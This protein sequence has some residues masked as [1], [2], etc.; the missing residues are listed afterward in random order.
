MK[1]LFAVLAFVA[2]TNGISV[3]YDQKL[4]LNTVDKAKFNVAFQTLLRGIDE[5]EALLQEAID[6]QQAKN[7]ALNPSGL[8]PDTA[9]SSMDT[10]QAAINGANV[11][12]TLN[13]TEHLSSMQDALNTMTALQDTLNGALETM[14]AEQAAKDA[15]NP[16]TAIDENAHLSSAQA[17]LSDL[18]A[19]QAII[20]T[21]AMD[22][23]AA[24]ALDNSNKNPSA[25]NPSAHLVNH[26]S[27]LDGIVAGHVAELGGE[28]FYSNPEAHQTQTDIDGITAAN[29]WLAAQDDALAAQQATQEAIAGSSLMEM[30]DAIDTLLKSTSLAL[31][32]FERQGF[33]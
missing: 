2:L 10:A 21:A 24:Q 4:N 9:L 5:M 1:V 11:P 23:E 12:P 28:D 6:A 7:E 15:T 26:Q 27:A 18:H 19:L 25:L 29:D 13:E 31:D 20:N 3:K 16:A 33:M 8:D 32:E 22:A 14:K 17:A 30:R